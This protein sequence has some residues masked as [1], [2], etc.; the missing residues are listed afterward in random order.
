MARDITGTTYNFALYI[1]VGGRTNDYC[2]CV[3]GNM[4]RP[5]PCSFTL[6]IRSLQ[7]TLQSSPDTHRQATA[8]PQRSLRTVSTAAPQ[9][10]KNL[11][12]L[13]VQ[14]TVLSALL[15]LTLPAHP[16]VHSIP[17]IQPAL[18]RTPPHRIYQPGQSPVAPSR[19]PCCG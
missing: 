13:V 12:R 8:H 6:A 10:S 4:P 5:R 17:A 18:V 7:P 3:F 11:T 1:G 2:C 15:S 14:N 9:D 16:T 19:L